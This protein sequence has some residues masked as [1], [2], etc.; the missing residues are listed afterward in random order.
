MTGLKG[1]SEFCFRETVTT[2]LTHA[3]KPSGRLRAR[4]PNDTIIVFFF[5]DNNNKNKDS[6]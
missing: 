5:A 3:D 1:N 4:Q 6:T 2:S